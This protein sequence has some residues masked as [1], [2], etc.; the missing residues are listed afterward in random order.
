MEPSD[1]RQ[2]ISGRSTPSTPYAPRPATAGYKLR[3]LVPILPPTTPQ[4][5]MSQT[6]S[7]HTYNTPAEI[8]EVRRVR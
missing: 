8:D 3:E 4:L 6:N 1:K 5:T 7:D 2:T